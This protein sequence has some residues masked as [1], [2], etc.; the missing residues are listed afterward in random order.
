MAFLYA[1]AYQLYNMGKYHDA[2]ALFT[3][4]ITLNVTEP[5]YMLGFAACLHMQKNYDEAAKR[6]MACSAL[7]PVS[8]IPYFHAYDCFME[9]GD[10]SSAMVALSMTI[11]RCGEKSEYEEIKNKATV[12]L[13]SLKEQ[14]KS[15]KIKPVEE[16]KPKEESAE[17]SKEAPDLEE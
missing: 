13:D 8:P 16:I 12:S 1:Q 14:V 17:A 6:Y 10:V 4:L 3:S 15:G 9:M 2:Q 11:K 5:K 7:D